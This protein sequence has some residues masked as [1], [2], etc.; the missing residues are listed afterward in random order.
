MSGNGTL[1]R[2]VIR[3]HKTLRKIPG[4]DSSA[5]WYIKMIDYDH[6]QLVS[7][8]SPI[9]YGK[10]PTGYVQKYPE[11]GEAPQ[12]EENVIYYIQVDTWNANGASGYFLIKDGK[13]NFA[14]YESELKKH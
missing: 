11:Q 1:S 3:G 8:L 12:L 13:I 7:R 6:G 9:S 14:K 4:P 2:L 10:L 5:V